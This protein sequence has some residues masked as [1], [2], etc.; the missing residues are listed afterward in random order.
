M[1]VGEKSL[2]GTNGKGSRW[3]PLSGGWILKINK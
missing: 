1:T 3:K 2:G